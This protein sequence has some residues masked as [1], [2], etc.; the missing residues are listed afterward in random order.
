MTGWRGPGTV[1]SLDRA[2]EGIVELRWQSRLYQCRM[3]DV[4]RAIAYLVLLA[5][6][7]RQDYP[8]E[9]PW[10]IVVMIVEHLNPQT[11]VLFGMEIGDDRRWRIDIGFSEEAA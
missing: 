6:F 8:G 4:R 2:D 5:S 1:V 9:S 7:Y 10:Q 11:S 3:P